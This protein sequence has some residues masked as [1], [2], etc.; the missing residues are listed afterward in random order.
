MDDL[1]AE[2]MGTSAS[3]MCRPFSFSLWFFKAALLVRPGPC[4]LPDARGASPGAGLPMKQTLC[5]FS[6]ERRAPSSG[7]APNGRD[8][9]RCSFRCCPASFAGQERGCVEGDEVML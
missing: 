5:G 8:G 3:C 4:G 6:V 2:V 7:P 9:P 1:Q